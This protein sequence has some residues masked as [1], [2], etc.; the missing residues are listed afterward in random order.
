MTPLGA[1]VP[2]LHA[3]ARGESGRRL[4]A[5]YSAEILG[6]IAAGPLVHLCALPRLG[7]NG[8]LALFAVSVSSLAAI[9]AW[10]VGARRVAVVLAVLGITLGGL[11]TQRAAPALFSPKLT[12]PALTVRSFREDEHFSVAVVDDGV[13]GERTLLTDQFR[14]AGNGPEYRYMRALG[15]LPVLLHPA[16]E[17]VAVLALGTG[18]TLGAVS[19]HEEVRAI[20]VLE[21]S[22]AVVAAA[23]LF[24]DLQRGA[25]RQSARVRVIVEDGRRTL[26]RSVG[27]YDVVT[28]EPLLPDS[29]FGVYLYT[30]EFYD[31]ARRAL[32]PGGVFC[33]W[34]PPHAVPPETLDAL[35]AAFGCAF[36]EGRVWLFGTQL[37]LT[38]TDTEPRI[39]SERL[40]AIGA[41]CRAALKELGLDTMDGVASRHVAALKAWEQGSRPLSDD[42]PWIA[43]RAKS[44]GSTVLGWLPANL[45]RLQQRGSSLSWGDPARDAALV[46]LREARIAYGWAELGARRG[47]SS[48]E[49]PRERA[50]EA[51]AALDLAA[52]QDPE[53]LTFREELDF[54]ASLRRGVSALGKGD[55]DTAARELVKAAALRPQRGDA[56]AYA[57]A[58]LHASG[59]LRAARSAAQT[60]VQI[61][62]QIAR[63]TAGLR[64]VQLGLPMEWLAPR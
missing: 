33:Q 20:D 25:L 52:A 45:E 27:R 51:L 32:R 46:A 60:A 9:A 34:I 44:S 38:G 28:M 48:Q 23:P 31:V 53:V 7:I 63:T 37:L 35:L 12:D 1:V 42:D 47:E 21:I 64:A 56:H 41:E 57:A 26:D 15:H 13:L 50:L 39:Q 6:G 8:T 61:C 29:P 18:T 62:P 54:I 59:D 22:S 36:P 4:G 16:P 55:A 40:R 5:L 14:A 10:R 30:P 2:C 58:A 3:L 49:A 11:A 24:D 19:L 43:W 17:R